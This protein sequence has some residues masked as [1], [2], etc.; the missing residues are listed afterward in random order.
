LTFVTA[1]QITLRVA[2]NYVGSQG[3]SVVAQI[4]KTR[5]NEA[6]SARCYSTPGKAARV[7]LGL[8]AMIR[9]CTHGRKIE[10]GK[11][12]DCCDFCGAWQP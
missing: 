5:S 4:E 9:D 1:N 3:A 11:Y 8:A 2:H 6:F 12:K 7:A 10:D